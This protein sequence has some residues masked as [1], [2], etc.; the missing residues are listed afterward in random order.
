MPEKNPD[1]WV[2]VWLALSNSLWQG[3]IMAFTVSL[4]RVMYDDKET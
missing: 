4:L 3:A 2:Q 1:L